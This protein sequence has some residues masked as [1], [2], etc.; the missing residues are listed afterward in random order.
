MANLEARA[1]DFYGT[2]PLARAPGPLR[3]ELAP[4][5]RQKRLVSRAESAVLTFELRKAAR[6][7]DGAP[8]GEVGVAPSPWDEIASGRLRV[9][10]RFQTQHRAYLVMRPSELEHSTQTKDNLSKLEAV[11]LGAAPKVCASDEGRALSSFTNDCKLALA[12]I[13]V[14][15]SASRAPIIVPMIVLAARTLC[16]AD[17]VRTS[18]LHHRGTDYLVSSTTLQHPVLASR[19]SPAQLIVTQLRAQGL[20][21][22]EI[23]ARRRTS[24]RTVANQL[25]GAF[26]RLGV[27]SRTTL[28]AYLAGTEE[29]GEVREC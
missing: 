20:S 27:S 29:G 19:L 15:A 4:G 28:L 18:R 12:A 26:H 3:P 9:C 16:R 25:A 2:E 14:Q 21:L 24:M 22:G 13:G 17:L 1:A 11:L 8:S 5:P 7:A 6:R 10:D 23:A